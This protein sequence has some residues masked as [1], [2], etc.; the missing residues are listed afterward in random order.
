MRRSRDYGGQP[1]GRVRSWVFGLVML[2]AA[3]PLLANVVAHDLSAG[4][5][6]RDLAHARTLA[7]TALGPACPEIS[8]TAFD[9][10]RRPLKNIFGFNGVWFARRFGHA[11]CTLI[12]QYEADGGDG[13]P[14]CRFT[15]PAVLRV[16][17]AKGPERIFDVGVGQAATVTVGRGVVRCTLTE[18]FDFP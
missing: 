18:P 2:C 4:A 14:A 10:L 1:I 11:D 6:A 15:A 8:E 16:T 17:P 7:L 13:Y 5:R 9:A 3:A 12:G